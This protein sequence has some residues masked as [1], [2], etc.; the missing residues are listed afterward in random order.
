MRRRGA[1]RPSV[2]LGP[3]LSSSSD[4]CQPGVVFSD[5]AQ[6]AEAIRR[7]DVSLWVWRRRRR[8]NLDS[9]LAALATPEPLAIELVVD[10]P[11]RSNALGLALEEQG[12]LDCTERLCWVEDI[13]ALIFLY[14]RV[15][16]VERVKV[17]LEEITR[18]SCPLFHVD[19]VD[20][21]LLCTYR[22][23][24]TQW[25]SG[26]DVNVEEL[27][28]Q[29]RTIE[30]ASRAILRTGAPVRRLATGWPALVKGSAFRGSERNG[31]VHRSP[32]VRPSAFP[33]VVL[34]LDAEY[35]GSSLGSEA[36]GD[37]ASKPPIDRK[38]ER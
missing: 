23:A 30:A 1:L 10:V 26:S 7:P 11:D 21:R 35:G 33:R 6:S 8:E 4:D 31:L 37:A 15:M 19:T 22:G 20:L 28:L 17:R 3:R 29:G 9:Y 25:L 2:T 27:G 36:T 14:A 12:V 34:R 32:P 16:T 5:S 13:A 38:G 18:S 24:G